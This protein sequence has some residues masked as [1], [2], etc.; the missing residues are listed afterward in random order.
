MSLHTDAHEATCPVLGAKYMGS[1]IDMGLVR[2]EVELRDTK[3]LD[4]DAKRAALHQEID[5]NIF[6]HDLA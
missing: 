2:L 4:R 1:N 6:S 3:E 5:L